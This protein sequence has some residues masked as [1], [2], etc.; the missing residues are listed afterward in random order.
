MLE[1]KNTIYSQRK[2]DGDYTFVPLVQWPN[3][4]PRPDFNLWKNRYKE[5]AIRNLV[6]LLLYYSDIK[7]SDISAFLGV[8]ESR[9][10]SLMKSTQKRMFGSNYRSSKKEIESILQL[11]SKL[12]KPDP[13][14]NMLASK[15]LESGNR[16]E[17]QAVLYAIDRMMMSTADLNTFHHAL[18]FSESLGKPIDLES[19][20]FVSGL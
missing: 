8:T 9:V 11:I 17:L 20:R 18:N 10:H 1:F 16:T 4:Y 12:N 15:K 14:L 13:V 3:I 6:A 2:V 7:V 19:Y 5:S